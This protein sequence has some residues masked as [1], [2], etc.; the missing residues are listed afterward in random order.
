MLRPGITGEAALRTTTENTAAAL[1]SGQAQVLA[2]PAVAALVE[3]ACWQS[4][5]GELDFGYTTVGTR[6]EL[7]HTAPTPV[8]MVVRCRCEL[9]AVE[10]RRL[11]F[12]AAV[13]DDKGEVARA[14]HERC[15]VEAGRFQRKADAK[16]E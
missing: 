4:V 14:V 15:I 7:C 3:K 5:A 16:N 12:T 13:R 11:T 6:L 8:G 1:G 2:T 9:T 10:D